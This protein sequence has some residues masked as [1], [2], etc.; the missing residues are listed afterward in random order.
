MPEAMV[1]LVLLCGLPG[2][3]KTSLARKLER[4]GASDLGVD[5]RVE[6][7]SFDDL[8]RADFGAFG[9]ARDDFEPA[10]W[11]RCQIAMVERVREWRAHIPET[12]DKL[13][14]ARRLVLL[15]DDNFQ[16]RSLRKRFARL[17]AEG[18]WSTSVLRVLE[19]E[20]TICST[21]TLP[22]ANCGFGILSVETPVEICRERNAAR[23][24]LERVP[25]HAFERMASAFEAPNG[26]RY[27]FE[28][29]SRVLPLGGSTLRDRNAV[30]EVLEGLV[31]AADEFRVEAR[32]LAE[33][34]ERERE[35]QQRVCVCVGVMSRVR[36]RK[37][38]GA[39]TAV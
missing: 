7:L 15:L 30:W 27:P 38:C 10:E 11:K 31:N 25:D 9:S 26:R 37:R 17:A 3:G 12:P 8:F 33:V 20:L 16:L 23:S 5:W 18:S 21:C 19:L 24:G 39:Y 22:L 1:A 36:K 32:R 14:G 34:A 2:A 6:R 13:T 29:N 4:L 35:Q 28:R